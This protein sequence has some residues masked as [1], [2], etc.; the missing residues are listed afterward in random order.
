MSTIYFVGT[1]I[2]N[3]SDITIRALEILREVNLILAEDT[4]NTK[5]LLNRYEIKTKLL[6]YHEHNK[7]LRLPEIM[8]ALNNGDI[9]LVSDAGTPSIHDPGTLLANEIL[10]TNHAIVP[11]PGPSAITTALSVSGLNS[12]HF[13]F[14]GFLPHQKM[15]REKIISMVSSME[16]TS[17][18]FETPHRLVSTLDLL[19][20]LLDPY[21]KIVVC[22]ELT[23]IYEEIVKTTVSEVKSKFPNP[24]GEFTIAIEGKSDFSET[25]L[26]KEKILNEINE[27]LKILKKAGS[28]PKEGIQW[29][30]KHYPRISKKEIYD[31]WITI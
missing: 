29:I 27:D 3:L 20:K 18:F 26:T 28:G 12:E 9:A 16:N 2:G 4:R 23:K 31:I 15:K 5:K 22:R 7:N 17:I 30:M 19:E 13:T 10:E 8:E 1:P 14:F 11:I 25:K 6:S 24:K 21:R